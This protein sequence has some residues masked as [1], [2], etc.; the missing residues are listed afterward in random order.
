MAI[1][2]LTVL[3][4]VPWSDVV[5]NAPKVAARAKKLWDN[6]ASKTAGNPDAA[7]DAAG[8]ASAPA[9]LEGLQAQVLSLHVLSADL[10]QRLL[11]LSALIGTLAEQ[12]AQL[13]QSVQ[14]L[15]RRIFWLATA[16][17]LLALLAALATV[18]G[19]R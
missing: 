9:S 1:G 6:V 10:Q 18:L 5:R 8:L 19:L 2:W 11:D 15:R 17:L 16:L 13:I 12:N 7:A 3:Q 4:S 14:V